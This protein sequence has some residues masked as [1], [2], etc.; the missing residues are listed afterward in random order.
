MCASAHCQSSNTTSMLRKE[1][2]KHLL[3]VVDISRANVNFR[4]RRNVVKCFT[5][6]IRVIIMTIPISCLFCL[7]DMT[8]Y[9]A[10]IFTHGE[11]HAVASDLSSSICD[12]IEAG[13]ISSTKHPRCSMY[14]LLVTMIKRNL[15]Q[16]QYY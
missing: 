12:K 9:L 14:L 15:I 8:V 2:R 6:K 3:I 13:S 10:L 16:K 11:K 4:Y 5:F 7:T 1:L